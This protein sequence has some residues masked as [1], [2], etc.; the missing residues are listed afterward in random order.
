MC[1]CGLV[2]DLPKGRLRSLLRTIKSHYVLLGISFLC[3][4][5]LEDPS[6]DW[7]SGVLPLPWSRK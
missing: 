4:A 1:N 5:R 3:P 7:A 2:F 6:I